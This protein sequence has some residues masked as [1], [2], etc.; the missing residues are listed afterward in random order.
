MSSIFIVVLALSF[1]IKLHFPRIELIIKKCY[2]EL[3][4]LF[5]LLVM[6]L[7][8]K[9]D[10]GL[11]QVGAKDDQFASVK[12]D[13]RHGT[14]KIKLVHH[15]GFLICDTSYKSKFCMLYSKMECRQNRDYS[16]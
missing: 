12:V 14:Y 13:V 2:E 9:K 6:F 3:Q 11:I 5:H 15:S 16:D 4:I 8:Q 7:L 10:D 1:L